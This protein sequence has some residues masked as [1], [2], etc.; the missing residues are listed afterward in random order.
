M[1]DYDNHLNQ[2]SSHKPKIAVKSWNKQKKINQ[3]SWLLMSLFLNI[4]VYIHTHY[5]C[6]Y[7]HV[8][9]Y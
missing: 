6:N 5:F 4:Y 1:I 2:H 3:L 9:E 7:W 8:C